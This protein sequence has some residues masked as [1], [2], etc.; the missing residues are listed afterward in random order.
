MLTLQP[1]L[2]FELLDFRTKGRCKNLHF[3]TAASR[4]SRH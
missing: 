2:G 1:G 4:P 3:F